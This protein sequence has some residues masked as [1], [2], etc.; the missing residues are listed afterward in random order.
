M[1]SDKPTSPDAMSVASATASKSSA[2]SATKAPIVELPV[3][4]LDAQIARVE[5][6]K[7]AQLCLSAMTAIC[8]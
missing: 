3:S 8:C 7:Q 5:Q 6:A 4:E 1:T 2:D